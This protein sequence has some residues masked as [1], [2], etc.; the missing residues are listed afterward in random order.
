MSIEILILI[1][2]VFIFAGIIALFMHGQQKHDG[3][4]DIVLQQ[5]GELRREMDEKLGR[6]AESMHRSLQ[7]QLSESTKIVRE[8]TKYIV[9]HKGSE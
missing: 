1:V 8:V 9:F 2:G 6:S 7:T 3:G 5:L 4:A